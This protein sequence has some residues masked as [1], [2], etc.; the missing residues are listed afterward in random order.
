[1]RE[2]SA[3]RR[4]E[5]YVNIYERTETGRPFI[6]MPLTTISGKD[7]SLGEICAENRWVLLDFWATWC[8]PCLEEIP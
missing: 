1:M 3:M 4:F 2:L 6:D 5:E 7:T 8:E